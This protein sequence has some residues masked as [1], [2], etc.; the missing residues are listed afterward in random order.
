LD[1]IGFA[2]GITA[3][4][5]NAAKAPVIGTLADRAHGLD[6]ECFEMPDMM[7]LMDVKSSEAVNKCRHSPKR[8]V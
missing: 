2:I 4:G 3:R 6:W 7:E 5:E 8:I 1:G